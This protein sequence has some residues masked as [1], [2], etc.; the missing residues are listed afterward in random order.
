M[1][2]TASIIEDSRQPPYLCPIDLRK[3]ISATGADLWERNTAML[4]FCEKFP[5]THLFA[6]YAAWIRARIAEQ[7][8]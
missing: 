2:G 1:Q 8:S 5:E 6:A 7:K 4:A 3:V